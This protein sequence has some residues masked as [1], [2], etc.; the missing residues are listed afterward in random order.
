MSTAN[1]VST[2]RFGRWWWCWRR[3]RRS[4]ICGSTTMPIGYA[5]TIV[6]LGIVA[7]LCTLLGTVDAVARTKA[8]EP[9]SKSGHKETEPVIEEVNAKQLERLLNEKDFVA[10]YWCKCSLVSGKS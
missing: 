4:T 9:R 6:L 2:V 10:V 1:D 3:R 5:T 7:V 8:D